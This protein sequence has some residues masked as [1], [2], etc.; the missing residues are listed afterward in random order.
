MALHVY[1]VINY[2]HT[3]YVARIDLLKY[4]NEKL[5]Y[6]SFFIS[7]LQHEVWTRR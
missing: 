4:K 5:L 1:I 3:I 2:V 6:D 7:K